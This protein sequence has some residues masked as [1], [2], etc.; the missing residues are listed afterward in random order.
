MHGRPQQTQ[1]GATRGMAGNKRLEKYQLDL[2]WLLHT[3]AGVDSAVC[4]SRLSTGRLAL[5]ATPI[6]PV[7]Q[8][9]EL[10]VKR[11][12]ARGEKKN[13]ERPCGQTQG[14]QQEF[15][16]VVKNQSECLNNDSRGPNF[17]LCGLPIPE[18]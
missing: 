5:G 3:Q 11:E 7:Q 18:V 6:S 12:N 16:V 8:A 17:L 4:C 9:L 10:W 1:R 13:K 2:P 14:R 15:T